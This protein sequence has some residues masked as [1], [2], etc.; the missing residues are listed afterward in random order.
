M[1]LGQDAGQA[2]PQRRGRPA[3]PPPSS[4]PVAHRQQ[5][6]ISPYASPSVHL[7]WGDPHW[8]RPFRTSLGTR[9][10]PQ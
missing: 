6:G 2:V 1:R 5:A 10:P 7:A 3:S 4:G 9:Q 8:R